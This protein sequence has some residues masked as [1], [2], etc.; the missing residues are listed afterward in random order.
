MIYFDNAATTEI[1]N[2][3]KNKMIEVINNIYGNPSSK[4]SEQALAAH[5][6]VE[7]ARKNI[8]K[9]LNVEP[10]EIIFNSGASEGNNHIIKGIV[11]EYKDTHII[12]SNAEHHSTLQACEDIKDYGVGSNVTFLKV[13]SK[14]LLD[15]NELKSTINSKT[16][17]ITI[18]WANNEIGSLN[19][20]YEISKICKE[21]NILLHVDAT[22]AI[23]KIDI[24][25]KEL[26][27]DFL[28]FSAHKIYGPKGIG[29]LFMRRDEFGLFPDIKPLISGSQ[30]DDQRGGTHSIHNI[31]GL[32]EAIK[33]LKLEEKEYRVHLL[34]LEKYFLKKI[35]NLDIICNGYDKFNKVPGIINI[36]LKNI[37][38]EILLKE[39]GKNIAL[40]TGSACSLNKP[41]HV[42]EAIG[43][44]KYKIRNSVR[45]SFGKN[46]TLLEIDTFVDLLKNILR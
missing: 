29:V 43:I 21:K 15:I 30:E 18:I 7:N 35:E 22:Q 16:K 6:I 38:N 26:S 23:G 31:A 37:N 25:L 28:T 39:L 3:V 4:Y 8:S 10:D 24:N 17:L 2:R 42:L 45:V 5:E 9:Y 34:K 41:S 36:Q 33:I 44:D 32:N 19:N 11:L 12:T 46:N 27:I 1:D 20:I 14:G 13:N 40:S